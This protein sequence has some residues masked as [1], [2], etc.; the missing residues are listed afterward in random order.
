ML[1]IQQKWRTDT[2]QQVMPII[3]IY[4]FVLFIRYTQITEITVFLLIS[5]SRYFGSLRKLPNFGKDLEGK[6]RRVIY[7]ISKVGAYLSAT[8]VNF[9]SRYEL[10]LKAHLVMRVT[11]IVYP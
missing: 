11:H 10:Y 7:C 6:N 1:R 2:K 3:V 4:I 5:C 9:L 8:L